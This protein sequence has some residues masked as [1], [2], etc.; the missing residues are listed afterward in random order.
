[1]SR[2]FLIVS[3]LFSFESAAFADCK[4]P[5]LTAQEQNDQATYIFNGEVWNVEL[6]PAQ[7]TAKSITLDV[8]DVFKGDPGTRLEVH[9][10]VEKECAINFHEGESYLVYARW[11]WGSTQTSRCWGTKRLKDAMSDGA[12]LG[13]GDVALNKYFEKLQVHCM[14]R[15]DTPCCLDSLKAMRKGRYVPAPDTGCPDGLIPDRLRCDGSYVWCV[16]PTD[17][18]RVKQSID[19]SKP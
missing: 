4:C 11:R 16:P 9:Q 15:R 3:L 18:R 7:G 8:V 19:L 14:G 13:P 6:D 12:T 17:P 10:S 5:S 2:V 1:M